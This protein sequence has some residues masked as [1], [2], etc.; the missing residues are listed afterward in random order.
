[1]LESIPDSVTA[2]VPKDELTQIVKRLQQ[3]LQYAHDHNNTDFL[4]NY[5]LARMTD[6]VNTSQGNGYDD[7][8]LYDLNFWGQQFG[9]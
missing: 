5:V 2:N 3:A 7:T 1:M 6:W 8:F 4:K 9:Y